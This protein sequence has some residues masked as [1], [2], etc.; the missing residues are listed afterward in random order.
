M[1]GNVMLTQPNEDLSGFKIHIKKEK[2]TIKK[3]AYT[4]SSSVEELLKLNG[5]DEDAY[6]MMKTGSKIKVGLK[7]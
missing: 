6:K 7:Y 2:E 1:D 3:L 5:F 4:Y